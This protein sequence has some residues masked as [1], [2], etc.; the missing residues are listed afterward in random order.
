M[1]KS[2]SL[3]LVHS[4]EPRRASLLTV[5]LLALTL[6]APALYAP[7]LHAQT[8][9]SA[10]EALAPGCGAPAAKFSVKTDKSAHPFAQPDPTKAILYFIQNDSEFLSRPQPTTRIGVNGQWVGATGSNSYF[11]TAVDPGDVHLCA[12]WQ[13]A[14]VLG[15]G[16]K[17]AA[18]NLT[19]Q[20]GNIYYFEIKNKLTHD[21]GP[22]ISLRPLDI[23]QGQL[24][25]NTSAYSTSHPK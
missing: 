24:Q 16:H 11:Y 13:T 1:S 20:A 22:V 15:Q 9:S 14:V 21:I 18:A 2:L 17:T 25:I 19:A 7:A 3:P 23:D 4:L 12:S 8:N 5:T 6:T 10:A